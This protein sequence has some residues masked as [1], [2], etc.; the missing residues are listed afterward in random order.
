MRA[1]QLLAPGLG[2]LQLGDLPDPLAPGRGE[3]LVRLRAA[4][5][6]QRDLMVAKGVFGSRVPPGQ[7]PFSDAA[8]EVLEVGP[9]VSRVRVADRVALTFSPFEA[10]SHG[11]VVAASRGRGLTTPG[12]LAEHLL[13]SEFDL[14]HLPPN[15]TF[16]Q[17][18]T[19][20]CAA[21]TA[22]CALCAHAPLLPGETVLVQG[23]GGVSIFALQLARLFGARVIATSS[24]AERCARLSALGADAVIDSGL[25]ADWHRQVLDL[26]AGQGVD[27]VV[28][29]GGAQTMPL[30]IQATRQGGRISVVGLLSGMPAMGADFF[31]RG[32][33][34]DTVHVGRREHLE[35]LSRAIAHHALLP[36][37]DRVFGFAEASAA[38]QHVAARRHLGKVVIRVD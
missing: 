28:E 15:V 4:S 23:S 36:V 30:A 25:H 33:H 19:L 31:S 3:V 21:V 8:G 14:V 26:T 27:R 10:E 2:G 9:G 16:E 6:N 35:Q 32:L 34:I 1:W 17:G 18:S 11:A 12:V 22:W 24:S 7:V 38:L 29:V 20:P 5:V 37:I 13:V